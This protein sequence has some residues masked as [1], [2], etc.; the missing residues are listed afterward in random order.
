MLSFFDAAVGFARTTDDLCACTG[1]NKG[2]QTELLNLPEDYGTYCKAWDSSSAVQLGW[3]GALE[4]PWCYVSEECDR[5]STKDFGKA[6]RFF[7]GLDLHYS[8]ETC[9]GKDDF[10]VTYEHPY[11][12]DT[13]RDGLMC[14]DEL[15][16]ANE[17]YWALFEEVLGPTE[18]FTREEYESAMQVGVAMGMVPASDAGFGD[19]LFVADDT[20]KDGV[21]SKD[22]WLNGQ[23]M[24]FLM[25]Q[26]G[27]CASLDEFSLYWQC[28]YGVLD[29]QVECS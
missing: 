1:T 11:F 21:L 25:K 12:H 17:Q 2:A 23:D 20:D 24:R 6:S 8:Y 3:Q 27:H 4:E 5:L 22:E 10:T 28:T 7:P 13:N 29:E 18:G 19:F 26:P 14:V 16:E 15:N 9:H